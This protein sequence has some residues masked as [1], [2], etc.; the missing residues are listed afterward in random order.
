MQ[1]VQWQ[2]TSALENDLRVIEYICL[3]L[4]IRG[5]VITNNAEKAQVLNAFFASVFTST[6]GT[7]TLRT[8]IQI[9]VN[10]DP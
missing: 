7:Q 4:K 10:A 6:V 5:E 9:D 8:E 2:L 1:A 3:L